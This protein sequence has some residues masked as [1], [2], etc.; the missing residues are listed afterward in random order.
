MQVLDHGIV[1]VSFRDLVPISGSHLRPM[2]DSPK[3]PIPNLG[4]TN[5]S[6]CCIETTFMRDLHHVAIVGRTLQL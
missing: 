3:D 2:W 5:L 1:Q 6:A 4:C